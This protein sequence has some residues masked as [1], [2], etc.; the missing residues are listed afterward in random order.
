MQQ[1]L[2]LLFA[3]A[4]WSAVCPLHKSKKQAKITLSVETLECIIQVSR[5]GTHWN[6]QQ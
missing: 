1:M 6:I 4:L 3:A 2:L 5:E